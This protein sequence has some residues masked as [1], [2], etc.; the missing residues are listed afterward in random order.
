[1]SSESSNTPKNLRK[2]SFKG[3]GQ[4]ARNAFKPTS[5]QAWNQPNP[6]EGPLTAPTSVGHKP[7]LG[8]VSSRSDAIWASLGVALRSLKGCSRQCPPLADI[9]TALVDSVE[10]V[11]GA[12]KLRQDYIA[13]ALDLTVT[14][15]SLQRHLDNSNSTEVSK[16]VH[17][18]LS[19]IRNQI[20]YI[21]KRQQRHVL[22]R[23]TGTGQDEDD[24]IECYR[25]VE[26]HLRRLQVSR[27]GYDIRR[28]LKKIDGHYLEHVKEHE[29]ANSVYL[30]RLSPSMYARY[31]SSASSVVRRRRCTPNTRA[32]IRE[33]IHD[34]ANT[35]GGPKIYWLNGMAGTGKTTIIY[36]ICE[37]LDTRCQLG[38]S[39]FCSRLLPECRDVTKLMPTIAYQLA[40]FSKPFRAALCDTLAEDQDANTYNVATQFEKLVKEPLL[41]VMETLPDNVIIVIDALDELS[42][43][44]DARTILDVL[45]SCA[46]DLPVR[47]LV[48]CRPEPG[49]YDYI[50]AQD[51][52][53]RTMLHLHDIERSLVQADIETYLTDELQP[54]RPS[55]DQIRQLAEQAGNLFIYAATA[56]RYILPD[57]PLV[58]PQ[59]RL[60]TM[61]SSVSNSSSKRHRDI[62]ALYTTVLSSAFEH[63]DLEAEEVDNIRLGLY[64]V[65]CAKEPMDT[66]TLSMLLAMSNESKVQSAL[67]PLWSVLHIS[68]STGVVSA[69]HTSFSDYLLTQERSGPY[70]CDEAKQSERFAQCCFKVMEKELRYNICGLESSYLPDS[71]VLDLVD[72]ANQAISAQL[73]YACKY[74]GAHLEI[75]RNSRTL[76]KLLHKFLACHLLFWMEV[77]N[78]KKCI[79]TSHAMLNNSSEWLARQKDASDT[80]ELSKDAQLF[81]AYFSTNAVGRSTPHI[82]VSMLPFWP[83]SRPIWRYYGKNIGMVVDVDETRIKERSLT[84]RSTWNNHSIAYSIAVSPDG[85]RIASGSGDSTVSIWDIRTGVVVVGPCEGHSSVVWSVAFS[86]DG[87]RVASGSGDFTVRI[88]DA[89]TGTMTAGPFEGHDHVICSVAFSYDGARVISGSRDGTICIWDSWTGTL[90]GGPLEAHSS[91]I[92]FV[93]F[94][95]DDSRVV[96]GSFDRIVYV[97]DT[98]SWS[99]VSHS[100]QNIASRMAS[101]L[102]SPDCTRI[103][104]APIENFDIHVRDLT[105]GSETFT[106]LKGHTRC[107][108]CIAFSQDGAHLVSGSEDKTVRV[109]DAHTGALL[110]GPFEGHISSVCSVAF[111]PGSDFVVSAS[112]DRTIRIW[113]TQASHAATGQ[114]EGHTAPVRSVAFSPDGSRVVSGSDDRSV[115]VWDAQTGAAIASSLTAHNGAVRSVTFSPNGAHIASGSA[116]STICIWDARTGE[117]L[118]GPLIKHSA[119]VN[120][121]AYSPDGI[122]VVS[123][124]QDCNIYVWNAVTGDLLPGPIEPQVTAVCTISFSPDGTK[125]VSGHLVGHI[126][127]W[128][129][130]T[131][132]IMTR[133]LQYRTSAHCPT[134]FSADGTQIISGSL[135]QGVRVWDVDT[136]AVVA[137]VLKETSSLDAPVTLSSDTKCLVSSLRHHVIRTWDLWKGCEIHGSFEGHTDLVQ[138]VAFSPDNARI[139]SGS[140]DCTIRIWDAQ[141]ESLPASSLDWRLNTRGWVINSKSED[142]LLWIPPE[143]RRAISGP[144]NIAVLC[145]E[146]SLVLKIDQFAHGKDWQKAYVD[147]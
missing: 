25:R 57:R 134:V 131:W 48:S 116:D 12:D 46:V 45:L 28:I 83:K 120:C 13:L 17:N 84:L 142:L 75:S 92:A 6:N 87:R 27:D 18:T 128:D 112:H 47:F 113:D 9:V 41:E 65:I 117:L 104:L 38:A 29:R 129:V 89:H 79:G 60:K 8:T 95:P 44:G 73:S 16:C 64:T 23:Y 115:R 86:P 22:G 105:D 52:L 14:V 66:K 42:M 19:V 59:E 5:S 119:P 81:V 94:S 103:A 34:W 125:A 114:F 36:S 21:N 90:L 39:F 101:I 10:L 2:Y 88:W 98:G 33:G 11:S 132:T 108:N 133:L 107:V 118:I 147:S 99:T 82:Y 54:I 55:A 69:L 109:W 67:R 123:G 78:L 4:R 71:H 146:G 32:V 63:P 3:L 127:V 141:K 70:W 122:Y 124:S 24:I 40:R 97:W 144:R 53:S 58:E 49:V 1:M 102:L 145:A 91:R 74:W 137:H 26:S 15:E 135:A 138:A 35:V 110:A 136:G 140:D 72:R 30:D 62:D 37:E 77:M 96:S 43:D 7:H 20:D 56:L 130:L 106:S 100:V 93:T 50:L 76:H 61:L 139:V 31:N 68:G 80:H 51:E 143:H 126:Y 121:V 85:T 111:L